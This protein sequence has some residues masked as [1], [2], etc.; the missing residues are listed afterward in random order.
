MLRDLFPIERSRKET[1][2]IIILAAFTSAVA[3][4][5]VPFQFPSAG[6]DP[7]WAQALVDAT[8][9]ARAFGKDIIFTYGPLHQAIT[10][11]ASD[12]L[13]PLIISRFAFSL[14]W[15]V[16]QLSIGM[17]FGWR[18]ETSVAL[19]VAISAHQ[20]GDANFYLISLVGILAVSALRLNM[21]GNLCNQRVFLSAIILSGSFLATLVKLSLIGALVPT[22]I[23][24]LG[25]QLIEV[26]EKRDSYSILHL[27]VLIFCPFLILYIAWGLTSGWSLKNMYTYYFG[28]NLEIVKGYSEAMSFEPSTHSLFPPLLPLLIYVFTFLVLIF[29][30]CSLFFRASGKEEFINIA[31]NPRHLLAL[32]CL[33]ILAWVVLKSSFVRDDPDHTRLGAIWIMSLYFLIIGFSSRKL[34]NFLVGDKGEYVTLS[35]ILT[36]MLSST[37][38]LLSNYRL[39]AGIP[40]KYVRGFFESF[41]LLSPEGRLYLSQKRMH[42]F[43]EIRKASEEYGIPKGASADIIPWDI[44]YV[45][46]N[47][48]KYTPRPIPQSYTVYTKKLQDINNAFY[49]SPE[50]SPDWLIVNIKDIDD[51]LPVGLDSPILASISNGYSF[52][53]RG[54]KESLV[55]KRRGKAQRKKAKLG[56]ADCKIITKGDLRW[57]RFSKMGWSSEALPIPRSKTEMVL[58]NTDLKA[59]FSRAI[60]SSLYRPFP[61][62]IEYLSNSGDALA[63]YRFIPQAGRNMLVYP[64]LG[65]NEDFMRLLFPKGSDKINTS[66]QISSFRFVTRNIGIPFSRSYYELSTDCSNR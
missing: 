35:L 47:Q 32:S 13:S 2:L 7:S 53:H 61:V 5:A 14:I 8:D 52:S 66:S 54:S 30:L 62:T 27:V 12:N 49:S 15:F 20:N 22:L 51:R 10:A 46:A 64:I 48:L 23:L 25:F 56:V 3:S 57:H 33:I 55:F 24:V 43:G 45:L 63:A 18:A 29:L 60:L 34:K 41:L 59:S 36:F 17:L 1:S 31:K 50:R 39:S 40:L 4:W 6:L 44:S 26:W 37:L 42:A 9:N 16:A 58:L 19:A 38:G 65:T 21:Q 28:A 11:H